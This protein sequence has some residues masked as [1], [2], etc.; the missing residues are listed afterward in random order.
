MNTPVEGSYAEW[1]SSSST[2]YITVVFVAVANVWSLF[3]LALTLTIDFLS[4]TALNPDVFVVAAHT[5][6]K[7]SSP[8]ANV[9]GDVA[10]SPL[11]VAEAPD[12]FKNWTANAF[13]ALL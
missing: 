7:T 4:T 11:T 3:F 6:I 9:N 13:C 2:L 10:F 8:L 1:V 5:L 12:E